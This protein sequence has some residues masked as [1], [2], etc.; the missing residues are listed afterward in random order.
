[1]KERVGDEKLI[2]ISIAVRGTSRQ[3]KEPLF[4]YKSFKLH[5]V[6]LQNLVLLLPVNIIN[7]VCTVLQQPKLF[8]HTSHYPACLQPPARVGARDFSCIC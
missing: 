5:S 1:M 4:R 8:S 2:I 7:L 6:I 3:K